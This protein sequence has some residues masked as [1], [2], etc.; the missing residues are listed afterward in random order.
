MA[1]A[2]RGRRLHS[3]VAANWLD[4]RPEAGL[5]VRIELQCALQSLGGVA[6]GMR[7]PAFQLLDAVHAQTCALGKLL[8]GH[9]GGQPVA[10]QK[11][12]EWCSRT[13]RHERGFNLIVWSA[14]RAAYHATYRRVRGW[15]LLA[16]L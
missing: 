6:V 3:H 7:H 4:R 16:R 8:L 5:V 11:L 15:P 10:A 1:A 13:G 12:S 14:G 9:P 2:G